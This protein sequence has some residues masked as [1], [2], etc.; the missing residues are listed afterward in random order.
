[1]DSQQL[2]HIETDLTNLEATLN[3]YNPENSARY[4]RLLNIIRDI[5]KTPTRK[6]ATK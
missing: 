1:M 6:K 5:I 2:D 3:E 4:L